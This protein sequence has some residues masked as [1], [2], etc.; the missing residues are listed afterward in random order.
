MTQ[1]SVQELERLE[2]KGVNVLIILVLEMEYLNIY[3]TEQVY[4]LFDE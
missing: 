3:L 2:I 1:E 4:K